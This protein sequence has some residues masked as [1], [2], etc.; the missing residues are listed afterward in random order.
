LTIPWTPVFVEKATGDQSAAQLEAEHGGITKDARL[1]EYYD[2]VGRRLLPFSSRRDFTHTFKVLESR[3]IINAFALGNGNVYV[4]RGLLDMLDDEAE[5]AEIAGHEIGHVANR[6]IAQKIDQAVGL[7]GLMA[8]AEGVYAVQKG[9]KV[10][11][12]SQRLIDTANAV[13]PALVLSGFGRAQELES[14]ED[15]LK[16]MARA[17]YDPTGSVRVFQ[18]FQK[19]EGQVPALEVFFRSHPLAKTRIS[20]L[21]ARIASKYPGVSGESYRSRFQNIVRGGSS[22]ADE[23][24]TTVLGVPLRTIGLVAGGTVLAVGLGVVVV[25]VL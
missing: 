21:E 11:E 9:D 24:A 23:V 22:L 10:S 4:T 5:L 14:D 7:M 25:S 13:V 8:L 15:G 2:F 16:Y 19:L 3:K 6:H 17:G 1:N 18:K 20:D 12:S